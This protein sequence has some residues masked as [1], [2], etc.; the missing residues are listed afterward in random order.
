MARPSRIDEQRDRLLPIVARAFSEWGYHGATTAKIARRCGIR[1]NILYRL[2]KDKKA[3]FVATLRYVS[4]LSI[5][6]WL[7]VGTTR[8]GFSLPVALKYEAGHIGE[9]GNHRVLFA[10]LNET[11]DPEIREALAGVYR[12]FH[13][14]LA[15]RLRD[16]RGARGRRGKADVD[17]VAWALV[18]LGTLATILRELSLESGPSRR[19]LV[20]RFGAQL[21]ET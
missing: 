3:M 5:R 8:T 12:D 10:A 1:E 2:W 20:L 17:T 19:R 18:G 21:L 13:S 14:F 7:R 16:L 11:N 4:D 6:T 15:T 9:F